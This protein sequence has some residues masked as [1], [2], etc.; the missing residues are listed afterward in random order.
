MRFALDSNILVYTFIRDDPARRSQAIDLVAR[1][2]DADCLLPV[3]VL[4]EFLNVIRR[5][6]SKW[7]D[8]ACAQVE[9]WRTVLPVVETTAE[10]I[11]AGGRLARLHRLQFWDS[12]LCDVVHSA[13]AQVLLSE[14]LQDGREL[15]GLRIVNPFKIEN[16]ETLAK[17]LNPMDS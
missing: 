17:L 16:R 13:G 5:K 3:Q 11:L 1:S 6:H 14:D 12:V 10:N 4:G 7:F 9:R 15:G 2:V 8:E